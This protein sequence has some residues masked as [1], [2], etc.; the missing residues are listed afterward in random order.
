M[1]SP[2]FTEVRECLVGM[3]PGA[4]AHIRWGSSSA[5]YQPLRD[6]VGANGE[7]SDSEEDDGQGVSAVRLAPPCCWSTKDE[8]HV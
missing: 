7:P 2:T 6:I 3:L 4:A 5:S 8:E 1:L